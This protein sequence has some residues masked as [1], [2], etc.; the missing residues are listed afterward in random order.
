M[1]F[2]LFSDLTI[3][4]RRLALQTNYDI[5]GSFGELCPFFLSRFSF[6][7]ILSLLPSLARVV[8]VIKSLQYVE[9]GT[10]EK[11]SELYCTL[12]T[13]RGMQYVVGLEERCTIGGCAPV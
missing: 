11:Q 8:A 9:R 3:S 12:S 10:L 6:L 2:F 5:C 1:C 13:L 4:A 7:C